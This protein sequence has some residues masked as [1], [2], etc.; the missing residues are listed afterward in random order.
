MNATPDRQAIAEQSLDLID[1]VLDYLGFDITDVH[2]DLAAKHQR[3]WYDCRRSTA[4]WR[5]NSAPPMSCNRRPAM[6]SRRRTNPL[7]RTVLD[8]CAMLSRAGCQVLSANAINGAGNITARCAPTWVDAQ[9]PR[10]FA[11]GPL[12]IEWRR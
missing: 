11:S 4:S 9:Y 1:E 8:A 12:R 6:R 10:Q 2:P 5:S 7:E 3:L